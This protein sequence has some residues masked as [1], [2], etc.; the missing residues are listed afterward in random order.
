MQDSR[1]ERSDNT[2]IYAD[3]GP[4]IVNRVKK[5]AV[6]PDDGQYRVQYAVINYKAKAPQNACVP[7]TPEV[8]K[9]QLNSGSYS[10]YIIF[11]TCIIMFVAHSCCYDT[12]VETTSKIPY[13]Q[14]KCSV[15]ILLMFVIFDQMP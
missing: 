8:N 7:P 3:I 9:A 11:S 6:V 12:C 10:S 14:C 15:Y 5:V 1:T 13:G 4:N 2:L